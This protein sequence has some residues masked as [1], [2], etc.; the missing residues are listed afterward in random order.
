M[1]KPNHL[2]AYLLLTLA[3]L[4]WSGNL[5]IG[6]LSHS[7]IPPFSFAFFRWL[8]VIIVL[9]PFYLKD[10]IACKDEVRQNFIKV[11]VLSFFSITTYTSFVY[12]GLHFTSVINTSLFKAIVPA[13]IVLLSY[14]LIGD[15]LSSHKIIGVALSLLGA[16][17]IITQGHL[18]Q[19]IHLHYNIGDFVIIFSSVGW[20][21]FSVLFKKFNLSI[22]LL[23]F[24]LLTAIIGDLTLLPCYLVELKLGYQLQ[25]SMVNVSYILYTALFS[26]IIAYS[27]WNR[28][29][30]EAGPGIAA[31]FFNLFP[32][33]GTMLAVIFLGET[34]RAYHVAGFMLVITG[35]YLVA[36][37]QQPKRTLV[38]LVE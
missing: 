14:F 13:L 36:K 15:S 11:L 12:L 31:L 37:Y 9:A 38:E 4:L 24:L 27:A 23:P 32:V 22:P 34:I 7:E 5:L 25:W 35:I 19:L 8:T 20:A 1:H 3:P 21:I 26:S 29:V 16:V 17:M 6:K 10:L 18:S 28:G 33:F 30:S 2:N